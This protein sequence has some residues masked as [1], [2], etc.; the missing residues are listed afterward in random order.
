[1]PIFSNSLLDKSFTDIHITNYGSTVQCK[2]NFLLCFFF[3]RGKNNE[4]QLED[5]NTHIKKPPNGFMLFLKEQNSG[6]DGKSCS[7]FRQ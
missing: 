2:R 4:S 6:K 7:C 3:H 5:T 1:M